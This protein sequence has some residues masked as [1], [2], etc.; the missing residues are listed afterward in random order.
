MRELRLAREGDERLEA[1]DRRG[2][3]RFE[4][5]DVLAA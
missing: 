5:V 2:L 1:G 4:L 3:A